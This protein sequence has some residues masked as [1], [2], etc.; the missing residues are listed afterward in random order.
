M[1][2]HVSGGEVLRAAA[3]V[4]I[5]VRDGIG[6][7]AT[8][9]PAYRMGGDRATELSR[10]E[11]QRRCAYR[12]QV[13]LVRAWRKVGTGWVAA[14]AN[15]VKAGRRRVG[16]S[17]V[18]QRIRAAAQLNSICPATAGDPIAIVVGCEGIR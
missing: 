2:L 17:L 11:R 14:D 15:C 10:L 6:A 3:D 5:D 7:A 1:D 18:D 9:Y 13:D 8:L 16:C 4:D 12:R